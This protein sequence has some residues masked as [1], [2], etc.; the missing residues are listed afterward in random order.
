MQASAQ[1]VPFGVPELDNVIEGGLPKGSLVLLAGTPG[2]GKTAFAA[3]FL[4]EGTTKFGEKGIYVSFAEGRDAFFMEMERYGLDFKKLEQEGKFIFLDLMTVK[5]EGISAATQVI[6]DTVTD[7]NASRL[8]IDSFSAMAQAFPQ[9]IEARSILHTIL[10]KIIRQAGCTTLLISEVP[11]GTSRLGLGIEEFVADGVLRFSQREVGGRIL[12]ILGIHKLRGTKIGKREHLFTL[13]NGFRVLKSFEP[14]T[15][16]DG[17]NFETL[18]GDSSHRSTGIRDLDTILG[19]GFRR[20]SHNLFEVSEDVSLEALTGFLA[21]IISNAVKAGDQVICIPVDG[22][23]PEELQ[24]SLKNHL[25]AEGLAAFHIF[26]ITGRGAPNTVNLGGATVLQPF[27][28]FWKTCRRLGRTPSRGILSI[29]GFDSLESRFAKDLQAMQGL[30]SE[31]IAKVRNAGDILVSI[32]RPFSNT[33]RQLSCASDSHF[34][35]TEYDGVLCLSGVKPRTDYY[36]IAAGISQN[37]QEI[38][39]VQVS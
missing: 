15:A 33:L 20:G 37:H 13:D 25:G 4:F 34:K 7:L 8:V 16:N 17:H 38:G 32:A 12:R 5:S 35:L 11:V 22:M 27:D 14:T 2:S 31:T 36:G 19:G 28:T 21:P 1:R 23:F 39:L 6:V 18:K 30:I 24:S 10:G 26:D 29:F 3:R 9:V